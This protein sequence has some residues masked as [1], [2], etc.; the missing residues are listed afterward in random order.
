MRRD[1]GRRQTSMDQLYD[2]VLAA[3]ACATARS[4]V[5]TSGDEAVGA[6]LLVRR[7]GSSTIHAPFTM[8]THVHLVLVYH[9][10]GHGH[11]VCMY[12]AATTSL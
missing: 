8:F 2:A 3:V 7:Q 4:K 11:A 1:E 10:H 9:G 6:S 12:P 5:Q